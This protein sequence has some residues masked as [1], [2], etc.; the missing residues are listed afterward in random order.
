MAGDV[1]EQ[2]PQIVPE[3]FLGIVKP[4]YKGLPS[5]LVNQKEL[6]KLEF[7]VRECIARSNFL[8]TLSTARE[9]TLNNVKAA[10][11]Q[12]DK[13]FGL[14]ASD[15]NPQARDQKQKHGYNIPA[16]I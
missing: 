3:P 16:F 5:T 7:M 6:V 14:L 11:D 15:P 4:G 9:S 1:F 13:T 12:R 2:K 10:R 8:L